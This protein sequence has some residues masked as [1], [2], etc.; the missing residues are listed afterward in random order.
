MRDRGFTLVELIVVIG[1][2]AVLLALSTLNFNEWMTRRQVERQTRELYS[3]LMELRV[4]SMTRK[5]RT[6]VFLGPRQL[7]F[8]TYSS[9]DENVITG[10]TPRQPMNG[11]TLRYEIRLQRGGVLQAFDINTDNI[12]FDTRG[13][14]TDMMTIVVLPLQSSGG[15]NCIVVSAGR[16]NIGRID[17]DGTCRQKY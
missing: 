3:D 9:A 5:Q 15:E 12:V 14:T 6:A 17:N 16:T 1:L 10:G 7:L 13:F 8:R 2:A 11:K 4:A